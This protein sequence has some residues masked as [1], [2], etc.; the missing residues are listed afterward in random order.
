MDEWK[1][2]VVECPGCMNMFDTDKFYTCPYCVAK[3]LNIKPGPFW[4][5]IEDAPLKYKKD[6]DEWTLYKEH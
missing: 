5:T 1:G 6:K 4:L 3:A 2:G